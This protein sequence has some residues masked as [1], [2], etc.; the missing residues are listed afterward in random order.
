MAFA[1]HPALVAPVLL[2]A[3]LL[4]VVG[5]ETLRGAPPLQ[6]APP[7]RL[8]AAAATPAAHLA[9]DRTADAATIDARP[10]FSSTRRPAHAA[11]AAVAANAALRLSGIFIGGTDRRVVFDADGHP[12]VAREGGHAG[13][14]TV[15]AIGADRVTVADA[16]GTHVLRPTALPPSATETTSAAPTPTQAPALQNL[17]MRLRNMPR[18]Q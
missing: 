14:Y 3:A 6:L 5:A 18:A 15:L 11:G 16:S 8:A 7:T 10:L 12:V 17:L 13:A 4:V 9:G 1:S 2:G